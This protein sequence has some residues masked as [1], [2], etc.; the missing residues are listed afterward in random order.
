MQENNNSET[1]DTQAKTT[2]TV[3]STPTTPS[4]HGRN[5][6]K[7][8]YIIAAV[9][10]AVLVI[11]SIIAIVISLTSVSRE[12][13]RDAF[14]T[15][16]DASSA[17]S[18]IDL[19][20]SRLVSI[21]SRLSEDE[22]NKNIGEVKES[23]DA[24][25]EKNQEISELKAVTNDQEAREKFDAYSKKAK[26]Y[27]AFAQSLVDSKSGYAALSVCESI[28][29][30]DG[31][32]VDAVNDAFKKC[33][34]ALNSANVKNEDFKSL[35]EAYKEFINELQSIVSKV[36]AIDRSSPTASSTAA[37]L[38]RDISSAQLELNDELREVRSDMQ[39][40]R[41]DK[42][43]RKELN[44]LLSYLSKKSIRE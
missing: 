20:T 2:A 39:E 12:D 25:K 36:A 11:G 30:S 23:I 37:Q 4:P 1:Q 16:G 24:L 6:K 26:E 19:D 9:V 10:G 5:N 34:D 3:Q 17:L 31:G 41:S 27:E 35:L 15:T 29:A 14:S 22:A 7:L 28:D 38:R 43:P 18:D 33:E 8:A 13:Y 21:S 32:S 44:D 42:M 40:D